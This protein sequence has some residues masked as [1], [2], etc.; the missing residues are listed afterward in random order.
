MPSNRRLRL[1]E[2]DHRT[3]SHEIILSHENRQLVVID[4]L[5]SL[6]H[7]VAVIVL[8]STLD[9]D[10][11]CFFSFFLSSEITLL[12]T[13]L[14]LKQLE[15]RDALEVWIIQHEFNIHA[16]ELVFTPRTSWFLAY[17]R[18][19]NCLKNFVAVG[20]LDV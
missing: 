14:F 9:L 16:C 6:T 7:E 1:P 10:I 11:H 20:S 3:R 19:S 18:H 17:P 12:R 4:N 8:V 5:R 13:E 2:K 15:W